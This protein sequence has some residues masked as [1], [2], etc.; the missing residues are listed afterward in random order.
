MSTTYE[1]GL[2][3]MMGIEF[4]NIEKE[5]ELEMST[6]IIREAFLTVA[7]DFNL[8]RE[9]A[10]SNAAFIE[11]DDLEKMKDKGILLIGVFEGEE[12]VGFIAIEKASDTLYYMEKLA[13]LPT[14]RHRGIGKHIMDYVFDLVENGGGEKVSIAVINENS[15]LK[16]WYMNY[17]FVETDIKKFAHLPF[18]VCFMEK[19]TKGCHRS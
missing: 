9:N 6:H 10:R 3:G 12:Q 5:R 19:G 11:V 13:V 14:F 18:T 7:K 8:T 15:V 1:R 16:K 4:R 17:G 2:E